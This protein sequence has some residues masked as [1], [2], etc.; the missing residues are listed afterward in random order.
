[1][2]AVG[3]GGLV[4]PVRRGRGRQEPP[5]VA[6]DALA[7]GPRPGGP[8]R[9][10]RPGQAVGPGA[11]GVRATVGRRGGLAE[12][13]G[14]PGGQGAEAMSEPPDPDA[15]SDV[16]SVPA[17]SL[18]VGL[19]AAFGRQ[20][21]GTRPGAADARPVLLREPEGDSDHVI[22]PNSDAMPAGARLFS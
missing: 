13:G 1:V 14:T 19:A 12:E 6:A 16:P 10:A 20:A 11:G 18:E 22:K 5:G 3:P 8:P 7:E 17:D 2:A 21:A 4:A 9:R 15:P